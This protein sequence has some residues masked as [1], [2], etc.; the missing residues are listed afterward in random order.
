MAFGVKVKTVPVSKAY[1]IQEL[2]EEIKDVNFS[3]G[4]P[5]MIKYMTNTVIVFPAL[6]SH[7]QVQIMALGLKKSTAKLAV[8]KGDELTLKG[9]AKNMILSDLTGGLTGLQRAVGNNV[10]EAERLVDATVQEL[11]SLNL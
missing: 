10:K 4:K 9:A 7:N 2:F 1:T 3:A 11:I 5:D 8:Q 6:D